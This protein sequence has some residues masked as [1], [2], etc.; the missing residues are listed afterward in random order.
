MKK[1]LYLATLCTAVLLAGCENGKQETKAS[2]SNSTNE[3]T[4]S[5]ESSNELAKTWIVEEEPTIKHTGVINDGKWTVLQFEQPTEPEIEN[6]GNE[7]IRHE[8]SEPVLGVKYAVTYNRKWFYEENL[9]DPSETKQGLEEFQLSVYTVG[10]ENS[11]PETVDLMKYDEFKEEADYVMESF[12]ENDTYLVFEKRNL[13]DSGTVY[14]YLDMET[15]TFVPEK[16]V[17]EKDRFKSPLMSDY[18]FI[19]DGEEMKT[20]LVKKYS[21]LDN[22]LSDNTTTWINFS[23]D[24][25]S[26]EA[27]TDF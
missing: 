19:V 17:E 27:F 14:L 5:T 8:I 16:K 4:V 11:K 1:Y 23:K 2:A 10:E 13:L 6:D 22:Y 26:A 25:K 7:M 21:K 24:V 20:K 18:L 9:E 12:T 3:T 15:L